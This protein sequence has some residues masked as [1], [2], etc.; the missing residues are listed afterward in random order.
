MDVRPYWNR[1]TI[2]QTELAS[3]RKETLERPDQFG[4]FERLHRTFTQRDYYQDY[5]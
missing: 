5:A 3:N 2:N 4:T 1:H